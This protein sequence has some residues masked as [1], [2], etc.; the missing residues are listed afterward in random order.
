VPVR[1]PR[2]VDAANEAVGSPRR[3]HNDTIPGT[4]ALGAC[5]RATLVSPGARV[6]S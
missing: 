1:E 3:D 5:R 6:A 2:Q 4:P